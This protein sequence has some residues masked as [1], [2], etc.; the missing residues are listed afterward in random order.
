MMPTLNPAMLAPD[1]GLAV[2]LGPLERIVFRAVGSTTGG[3]FDLLEVIVKPGGGPPEHL[4]RPN[5]E[6]FYVIEGALRVKLG[7]EIR[8]V[9]SGSFI[10]LP[11]GTPHAFANTSAEP[12]RTLVI[13]TPGG[14]Q[15]YFQALAPLLREPVDEVKLAELEAQYGVETTGPALTS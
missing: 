9:R 12:A 1:G 13:I 6:A 15:G 11:R 5:D 8:T 2:D 10:F 7:A 4:H 3:A 14:M